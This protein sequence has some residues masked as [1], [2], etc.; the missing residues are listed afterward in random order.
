MVQSDPATPAADV[1]N[2]RKSGRISH[3][4][5]LFQQDPNISVLTN[6]TGK[7]KRGAQSVNINLDESPAE[8]GSEDEGDEEPDEEELKEKKRK[9][10]KGKANQRKPAAKKPKMADGTPTKLAIRPASNGVKKP[11]KGKLPAK[12][13]KVPQGG[14]EVDLYGEPLRVLYIPRSI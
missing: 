8:E 3:K 1:T 14:D 7:R 9:A 13:P 6:G 12:K 4:P 5:V 10:P 2:R 11:R